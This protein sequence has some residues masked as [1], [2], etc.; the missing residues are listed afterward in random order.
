MIKQDYIDVSPVHLNGDFV[1]LAE[2]I[3]VLLQ[4][5]QCHVLIGFYCRK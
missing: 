5:L 2:L 4:L 3:L 1:L